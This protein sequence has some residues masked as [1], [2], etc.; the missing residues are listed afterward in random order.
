MDAHIVELT[1]G[2][3]K[4]TIRATW[5]IHLYVEIIKAHLT[6]W[7]S[8]RCMD[9]RMDGWMDGLMFGLMDRWMGG[10]MHACTCINPSDRWMVR[11]IEVET[12][13]WMSGL[14]GWWVWLTD[15]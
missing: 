12:D 7:K 13:V 15:G 2:D 3:Q 9:G 1:S 4:L 14:V 11:L 6:N 10:W 5:F 8:D